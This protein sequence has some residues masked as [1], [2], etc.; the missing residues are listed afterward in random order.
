MDNLQFVGTVSL[1][2]YR[3]RLRASRRFYTYADMAEELDINQ[4]YL[5]HIVN[6]AGFHPPRWV[7]RKLGIEYTEPIVVH[8]CSKCGTPHEPKKQCSWR[9]TRRKRDRIAISKRDPRS[10]ARSIR[11]NVHYGVDELVKELRGDE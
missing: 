8:P 5:W 9:R 1:N 4:H 10:A 7:C 11:N 3:K 2:E 6:T